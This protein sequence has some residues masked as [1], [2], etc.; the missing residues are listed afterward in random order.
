MG[1]SCCWGTSATG[2]TAGA[3]IQ[4]IVLST[5]KV[6]AVEVRDLLFHNLQKLLMVLATALSLKLQLQTLYYW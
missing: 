5:Q 4:L 2:V 1:F 6:Q 3:Y